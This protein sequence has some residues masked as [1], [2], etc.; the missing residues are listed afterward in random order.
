MMAGSMTVAMAQHNNP[1]GNQGSNN[2]ITASPGTAD[3]RSESGMNTSDA[4]PSR[5]AL[6]NY[7]GSSTSAGSTGRTIVPGNNSSQASNS[8]ATTQQR[9]GPQTTGGK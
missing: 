2:S 7:S 9:Q 3:S 5:T 1:A 4:G 8:S 6:G